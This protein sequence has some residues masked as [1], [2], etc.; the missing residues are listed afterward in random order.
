MFQITYKKNS[1][2]ID[3]NTKISLK[4]PFYFSYLI[5]FIYKV[6]KFIE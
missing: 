5:N 2:E 1:I 4:F 6:Y 3:I